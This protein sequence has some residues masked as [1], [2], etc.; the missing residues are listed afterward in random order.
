MIDPLSL[1]FA[2]CAL[3]VSVFT[4]LRSSALTSP[5]C[6]EPAIPRPGGTNQE[7]DMINPDVQTIIDNINA[8]TQKLPAAVAAAVSKAEAAKDSDHA[9]D[10][11]GLTAAAQ[12]LTDQI[13]ALT[14]APAAPAGDQAA[15]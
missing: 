1:I 10:V 14:P 5:G 4:F 2:S 9:D 3:G 11:A 6:A 15:S 12:A 8:Q 7:T 13:T